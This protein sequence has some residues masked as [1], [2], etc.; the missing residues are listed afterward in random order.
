M[1]SSHCIREI[2]DC[3]GRKFDLKDLSDQS[4]QSS[5]YGLGKIFNLEKKFYDRVD[6]VWVLECN[7][8]KILLAQ[9]AI[10]KICYFLPH[11]SPALFTHFQ[12][13]NP[14]PIMTLQ[15]QTN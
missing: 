7:Q 11:V 6:K 3:S 12:N 15:E 13:E 10:N 8:K 2:D 5:P 14:T 9:I 1:L 4:N